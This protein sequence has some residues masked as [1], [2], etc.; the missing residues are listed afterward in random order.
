MKFLTVVSDIFYGWLRS[1]RIAVAVLAAL[2]ALAAVGT[3]IP[4]G[5]APAFYAERYG[6]GLAEWI[7]AAGFDDLYHG[8]AFLGLLLWLLTSMI[9]CSVAH[10]RQVLLASPPRR[11]EDANPRVFEVIR[12]AARPERDETLD[13]VADRAAAWL[14]RRFYRV[15]PAEK[16]GGDI[17]FEAERAAFARFGAFTIHW[18]C[19]IVLLGG[20]ISALLGESGKRTAT[21][22]E[23]IPVLGSK[24][25]VRLD[26]FSIEKY[27]ETE[28]FKDL[29]KGYRSRITLFD[30]E[31]PVSDGEIRINEPF[32]YDGF[33]FYQMDYRAAVSE[34]TVR[35][36]ATGGLTRDLALPVGGPAGEAPGGMRV[37][38]V[39]FIPDFVFHEGKGGTRSEEFKNPALRVEMT[40]ADGSSGSKWIFPDGDGAFHRGPQPLRARLI[41]FEPRYAIGLKIVRDPGRPVLYA[42]LIVLIAGTFMSCAVF[43]RRVFLRVASVEDGVGVEIAGMSRRN[44]I[45]FEDELRR[46]RTFIERDG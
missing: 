16:T 46:L 6:A 30:G 2:A 40:G 13:R 7:T 27:A 29:H 23:L 1:I 5:N 20:G 37:R 28:K 41:A 4:Q 35:L 22:G 43:H 21:E 12:D 25:R 42:G 36:T 34:A 38:A 15:S 26:S 8:P 39:E 18:G 11:W 9:V 32:V 14:R 31:R 19:I 33:R 17:R 3:L 45:G 24:Y 10:L 44:R